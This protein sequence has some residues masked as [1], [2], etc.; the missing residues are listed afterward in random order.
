MTEN[1]FKEQVDLYPNPTAGALKVDLKEV[2]SSAQI[3]VFDLFGAVIQE[4]EF[5]NVNL[6]DLEIVGKAGISVLVLNVNSVEI[7]RYAVVKK[8]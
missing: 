7:G 8:D 6:L 3:Q 1:H 2:V 5:L 4:Q